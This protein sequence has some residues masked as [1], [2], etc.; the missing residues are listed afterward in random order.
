MENQL[1]IFIT[2]TKIKQSHVFQFT[3]VIIP[4]SVGR[5]TEIPPG[6]PNVKQ[7]L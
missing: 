3:F 7:H 6:P 1:S 2:Y 5:D 4:F